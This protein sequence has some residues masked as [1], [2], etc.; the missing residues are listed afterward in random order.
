MKL[1]A[2][3][4]ALLVPVLASA[5]TQA[6]IAGVVRDS[7]GAVLPGV[8][9]EAASP[10][11]IEKVRSV[12]T[13]DAGQYRIEAL[14]PGVY[15]VTF[16]LPGFTSVRRVGIELAGSFSAQ[17]NAEMAVGVVEETIT[18]SG[19]SPVVDVQNTV[20]QRV[21]DR[22]VIDTIPLSSNVFNMAG[23]TVPGLSSQQ[24]DVAIPVPAR[25]VPTFV[26]GTAFR[27]ETASKR[28]RAP[29]KRTRR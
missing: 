25:D 17:V 21:I 19:E 9:V 14:V 27:E 11:L 15:A 2:V 26:P 1:V 7:S 10:S 18:V 22:Q 28:K 8:K 13:N 6:S 4:L 16:T 24:P 20:Q 3:A 23:A 5:Q 12:V 29:A